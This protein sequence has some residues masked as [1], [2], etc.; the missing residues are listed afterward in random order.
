MFLIWD[1]VCSLLWLRRLYPVHK[2]KYFWK[3]KWRDEIEGSKI[4]PS[5]WVYLVSQM[6]AK[7]KCIYIYVLTGTIPANPYN[8]FF[9]YLPVLRECERGRFTPR[10]S[11]SS[12]TGQEGFCWLLPEITTCPICESRIAHAHTNTVFATFC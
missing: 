3:T 12:L 8:E 1:R 5:S 11:Y 2:K 7:S 9:L 10:L 6:Q 4:I